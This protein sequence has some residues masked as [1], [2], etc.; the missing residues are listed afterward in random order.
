M[1]RKD[2]LDWGKIAVPALMVGMAS[3]AAVPDVFAITGSAT[4]FAGDIYSVV[5]EDMLKGPIGFVAGVG[6]IAF[7]A[8]S[9]VTSRILPAVSA[10]AGGAIL[11]K[12]DSIV[13]TMGALI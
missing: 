3:I 11:L 8:Y 9:A 12:A 7:G 13:D 10:I 5:V 6:A 4:G 2:G 1:E